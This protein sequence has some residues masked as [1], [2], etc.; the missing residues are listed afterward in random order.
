VR[1]YDKRAPYA[2]MAT[3][4]PVRPKFQDTASKLLGSTA[5]DPIIQ[6]QINNHAPTNAKRMPSQSTLFI[7][8]LD[9]FKKFQEI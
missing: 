7:S 1:Q 2:N 5:M 9:R 8:A 3:A 6:G 4:K